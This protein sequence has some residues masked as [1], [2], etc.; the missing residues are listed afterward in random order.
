MTIINNKL[1]NLSAGIDDNDAVPKS[2]LGSHTIAIADKANKSYVDSENAKTLL[3]QIKQ[4]N[5]TLTVRMQNKTLLLQ[6]KLVNI[7]LT[8]K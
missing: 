6:I 2:Q 8:M 1:V 5:L 7:T 4:V 3:L